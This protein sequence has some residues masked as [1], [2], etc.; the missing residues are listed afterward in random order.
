[1]EVEGGGVVESQ[2]GRGK[3]T[4]LRSSPTMC[5]VQHFGCAQIFLGPKLWLCLN[6]SYGTFC[7]LWRLVP[8]LVF[9]NWAV[10]ILPFLLVSFGPKLSLNLTDLKLD[11]KLE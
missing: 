2:L 10:F 4:G 11:L 1:M 6:L 5:S 8:R 9:N 3:R 7:S